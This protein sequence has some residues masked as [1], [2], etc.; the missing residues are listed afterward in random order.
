M[1]LRPLKQPTPV[2]GGPAGGGR[3]PE[4]VLQEYR[5]LDASHLYGTSAQSKVQTG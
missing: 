2:G 4:A 3:G 1:S 5:S